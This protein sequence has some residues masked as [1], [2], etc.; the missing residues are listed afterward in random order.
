MVENGEETLD[1][2]KVF[3][4]ISICLSKGL[5][6]PIGSV[7]IGDK[8]FIQQAHR[9]RK[10]FGGGMRQAGFVAAAGIYALDNHLEKLKRDN[11]NAK[12]M[13]KWLTETA[14]VTAVMPVET[15]IVIFDLDLRIT[16][17]EFLDKLASKG[18]IAYPFG[19]KSIRFVSH[20]DINDKH[21]EHLEKS[22]KNI[23]QD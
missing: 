9:Y 2:G 14:F 1:Y 10:I 23:D 4:S 22:L 19:P 17:K 7:L 5:G 11:D 12:L 15:N 20:L 13:A 6:T 21:M 3:D 8:A 18:I 16:T